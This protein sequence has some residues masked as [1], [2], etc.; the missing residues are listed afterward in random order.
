MRD[1]FKIKNVLSNE[2]LKQLHKEML[3]NIAVDTIYLVAPVPTHIFMDEIFPYFKFMK[4]KYYQYICKESNF[5]IKFNPIDK[6]GRPN[7]TKMMREHW[8][9]KI[10]LQHEALKSLP[11]EIKQ[12]LQQFDFTYN[13]IQLACDFNVP[14]SQHF[15]YISKE[16]VSY[17]FKTHS[18][19]T[20][21]CGDTYYI[22]SD[23]AKQRARIYNKKKQLREV[24]ETEIDS[25]YLLRY[26]IIIKPTLKEQQP[27][28]DLNFDWIDQ[29]L[30]KFTFVPDMK[31]IPELNSNTYK[32]MQKVMR[33]RAKGYKGISE[34]QREKIKQIAER[35]RFDFVSVFHEN[36]HD[37]FNWIPKEPIQHQQEMI[38]LNN[39]PVEIIPDAE[40]WEMFS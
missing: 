17:K 16:K 22:Y 24:K 18:G 1:N 23:S 34:R 19:E 8:T 32:I 35:N 26:E 15:T 39:M 29:Y 14:Y 21:D 20:V 36:I 25:T 5:T 3:V 27:I 40:L 38:P 7:V 30:D 4:S 9:L 2:S 33:R 10:E 31:Q 12:L 13:N 28:H 11:V 37:L 6:L